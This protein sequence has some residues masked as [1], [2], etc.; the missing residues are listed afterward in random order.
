MSQRRVQTRIENA[1]SNWTALVSHNI[2]TVDSIEG[3][4]HTPRLLTRNEP[5]GEVNANAN[6]HRAISRDIDMGRKR[7]N[8]DVIDGVVELQEQRDPLSVQITL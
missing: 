1:K 4:T 7:Q 5:R 3:Q 2:P 6:R 8:F